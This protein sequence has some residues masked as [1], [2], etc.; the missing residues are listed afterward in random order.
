MADPLYLNMWFPNFS[1]S[2]MMPRALS[3]MRQFPF[4]AQIP[5][6]TY[7][8]VHPVSW[9]EATILVRR[10]SPGINPEYAVEIASDLLHQDYAYLFE[11]FWDL[12]SMDENSQ[13]WTL[14]PHR[15]KFLVH[16]SEFADSAYRED[17]HMQVD[18][19]LDTPFVQEEIKFTPSSEPR[20]RANV[21]KLVEFTNNIEKYCGIT[22]RVLWS[23]SD[24]NLAQKLVS[25]LQKVQ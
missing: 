25:R 7:V 21:Q 8:S 2:G 16:G 17:G 5:G 23:E 3:I 24:D 20:I 9:S 1:L 15:V 11:A 18:F 22:G 14:Q 10:F 4:S 6:I 13:R 19:G 12:W